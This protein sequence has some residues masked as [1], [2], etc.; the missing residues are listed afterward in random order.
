MPR[1]ARPAKR[2]M[3]LPEGW[4]PT[5]AHRA[6]ATESGLNVETEARKFRDHAKMTGRLGKDWDAGF[7]MWLAKAAEFQAARPAAPVARP[8]RKLKVLTADD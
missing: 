6:L 7:R 4:A 8:E 1:A 2:A 5:D 3:P